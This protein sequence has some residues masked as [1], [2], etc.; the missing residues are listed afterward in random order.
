M[1]LVFYYAPMST[2]TLTDLVLEELGVPCQ[3]VKLNLKGG[4]TKKPDFL[5]LNPNGKVP[6]I[7]HDDIPIFESAAITMYLGEQFGVEKK[8]YPAP[9]PKRG[10]AMKWIVWTNVTLGDSVYTWCRNTMDWTPADHRNAL[11]GQAAQKEIG[12]CLS[13]LNQ[14]LAGKKYLLGDAY[15]LADTHVNSYLDWLRY[16]KIDFSSFN[17]LSAWSKRCSDRP[18]YGKVMSAER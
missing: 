7:V 11:A 8:L 15:T 3:R 2:A 4:D 6:L 18:A 10:E 17:Y 13:I 5:K 1:S 9:G 14:E 12:N 16:M